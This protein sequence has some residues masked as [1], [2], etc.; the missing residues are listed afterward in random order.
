MCKKLIKG[1]ECFSGN[2]L[3]AAPVALARS[4]PTGR[5]SGKEFGKYLEMQLDAN[6]STERAI[7]D[8]I[9]I[10]G[11]I[12]HLTEAQQLDMPFGDILGGSSLAKGLLT[13]GLDLLCGKKEQVMRHSTADLATIVDTICRYGDGR[14]FDR[15]L[16]L[17]ANSA[18]ERRASGDEAAGKLYEQA[19]DY[20]IKVAK[21]DKKRGRRR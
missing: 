9:H 12:R 19:T 17:I 6:P 10:L 20:I 2:P 8:F 14:E 1:M 15:Y 7:S 18:A 16:Q 3:F 13:A 21:P 5:I 11:V 4:F